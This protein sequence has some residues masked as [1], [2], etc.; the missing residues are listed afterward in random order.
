ML[1]GGL[2]SNL[3]NLQIR[4]GSFYTDRAESQI[5]ASGFLTPRRGIIYFTDKNNNFNRVALNKKY[6]VVFAVPKKIE[7]VSSVAKILASILGIGEGP[8]ERKLSKK[9]DYELLATKVNKEQIDQIKD[10]KIPGIYIE[11]REFRFYPLGAIAAHILGFVG[12]SANDD[13]YKGR[14]GIEA[15]FENELRGRAGTVEG[16]KV[17]EPIPGDDLR[18]T[19]DFNIQKQ[20]EEILKRLIG[21]QEAAAGTVIVQ[22]PKTGKI[23]A[24][25]NSPTFDPNTY[26]KAT[27]DSFLNPGVQSIYE[28]GSVFKVITMAAGIDTGKITPETTF[29]DTG[30]LILNGRTISNFKD[31]VYGTVTMIEVIENSINTGAAFA[32]KQ[33]G[34]D[35]FL[36]YLAKFGFNEPTGITLPGELRGDFRSL[37]LNAR[38]INFATASFGQG[39]A[40]TPLGLINAIS[41][42]ANGGVLM[43]PY[44]LA[45]EEPQVI[46]R[47]I[48]L[49]TAKK[50]TA[51][52]VSAVKKA[53][54]AQVPKFTI[55]GKTGT[56]QI[57][58]FK[59]GG[60]TD[61][62][63]HTFAGFAPASN[64]R[65][66]I[67]IKIDKPDVGDRAAVTVVPAFREL[68]EFI[69]S[70]Y[71]IAPDDL[72]TNQ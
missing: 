31:K 57:P 50:V 48:K 3:Y 29:T 52:M 4:K 17:T 30:K 64:P 34:Y 53:E 1:F 72:S 68:A 11:S 51:M 7:N 66:S 37:K 19:I 49:E 70:Y 40:V 58:D 24:F 5:S 46:R 59:R 41:A 10:L 22:E 23:M 67:L 8:M 62:F 56:A 33:T 60:Y 13:E 43:K 54:I 12:P 71:N 20:A 21:E 15:Y 25:A 45:N 63:I 16:E 44:L 35:N 14:Y 9:N 2:I 28:P 42:I 65:F 38:E 27:V 55:A 18:L 47:V 6:P 36:N 39:I 69:L 32:V 61:E 26:S